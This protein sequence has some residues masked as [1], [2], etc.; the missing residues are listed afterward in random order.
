MMKKAKY[1]PSSGSHNKQAGS[2]GNGH[3]HGM[4]LVSA[5][6]ARR[7]KKELILLNPLMLDLKDS[8]REHEI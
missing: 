2:T 6:V 3:H 4:F 8:H 1:L 7:E 5:R